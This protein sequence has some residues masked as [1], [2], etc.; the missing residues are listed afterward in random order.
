MLRNSIR[1]CVDDDD[2]E[3]LSLELPDLSSVG[4][5]WTGGEA[6]AGVRCFLRLAQR[7]AFGTG[8]HGTPCISSNHEVSERFVGSSVRIVLAHI[9]PFFV[10]TKCS[11]FV[12]QIPFVPRSVAF[13]ESLCR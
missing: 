12:S 1:A 4:F 7:G 3:E 6:G 11:R 2:D 8:F 5:S 13:T 9:A 10:P